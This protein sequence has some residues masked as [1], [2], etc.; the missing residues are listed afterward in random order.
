MTQQTTQAVILARGLGTRMRSPAA[1]AAGGLQPLAAAQS[2]AA[3]QGAKGMMPFARPFLDYSLSAL[4]DAGIR[5]AILVVGPEHGQMR[6]YFTQTA[7]GRRVAVR[8]AI[9]SEPRGTADAV[10]AAAGAVR[11]APFLVLN[12]DNLYPTASVTRLTELADNGL[13]AFEA[14]SLVRH[15]GLEAERVLKFALLDLDGEDCLRTIREKPSPDDPL[16][17]RPERWVSMNLWS[18]TPA[19][20][21]ACARV[22]PSPRGELE[23]QDAVQGAIAGGMRLQAIRSHEPVLDLSTRADI[24]AVGQRLAALD[25]H[26]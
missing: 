3:E 23:L 17:R 20:F 1:A 21:A 12:A 5:E 9:Q 4:A 22:V 24:P 7:A 14:D 13:V 15:S 11:N 2:A 16:A 19:I 8:F 25:P 26:P 6:E 18:F 10:L